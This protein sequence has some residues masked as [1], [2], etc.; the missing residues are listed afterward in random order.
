MFRLL[1]FSLKDLAKMI[2][3]KALTVVKC[4]RVFVHK[5]IQ[6]LS[7][8]LNEVYAI[9]RRETSPYSLAI[10][11]LLLHELACVRVNTHVPACAQERMCG[12]YTYQSG[13]L[14]HR[15]HPPLGLRDKI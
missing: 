13:V 14:S 11:L 1:T 6:V 8:L 9:I 2:S 7:Y 10:Y 5:G 4:T 3:H 15:K 12:G